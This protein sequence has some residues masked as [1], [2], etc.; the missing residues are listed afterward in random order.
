MWSHFED[1]LTTVGPA[2][3]GVGDA[4][5]GGGGANAGAARTPLHEVLWRRRGVALAAFGAC[6]VA[7]VLYLTVA[8]PRYLGTTRLYVR[9][10][11]RWVAPAAPVAGDAFAA[12]NGFAE[13]QAQ[14]VRSVPVL[15]DALARPDVARLKLF[16][17]VDDRLDHLARTLDVTVGRGDVVTVAYT[18]ADPAEA[19]ALANAVADAFVRFNAP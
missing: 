8:T 2:P 14:L 1:R 3:L 7:A 17:G 15:A 18:A 4:G 19:A 11:G 13:A 6:A 5:A 9:P 10:G 12:R 16:D